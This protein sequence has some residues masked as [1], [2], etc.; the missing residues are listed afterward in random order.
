MSAYVAASIAAD[1]GFDGVLVYVAPDVDI[2]AFAHIANAA[3]ACPISDIDFMNA[4]SSS[5]NELASTQ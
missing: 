3:E 1:A 2:S 4:L 5:G